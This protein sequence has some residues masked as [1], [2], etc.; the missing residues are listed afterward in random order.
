MARGFKEVKPPKQGESERIKR[1][2]EQSKSLTGFDKALMDDLLAEYDA[3]ASM[4]EGLR[5][6]VQEHGVMVTKVV[7]AHN[8]R[9]DTVENPE[10][11]TYQKGIARLGDLAKKISDFAKRSDD[12]GSEEDELGAFIRR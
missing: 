7:G 9:E 2:K 5:R 8:P 1:L 10:F 3:L 11:T 6:D 12:E 4:V